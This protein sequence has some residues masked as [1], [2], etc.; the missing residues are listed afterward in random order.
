MRVQSGAEKLLGR[1][2]AESVVI[3][4][5]C[6][7]GNAAAWLAEHGHRGDYLGID[8]SPGLLDIACRASYPF[9]AEFR[10]ADFLSP[11]WDSPLA[12]GSCEFLLAFAVL[13]HLPGEAARK[14]FAAACRRLV[15][16]GGCVFLSSWQFLRSEKLRR[17]RVSWS[18]IGLRDSDVDEGDYLVDWR[19]EGQGLRYVHVIGDEERKSLA[20]QAGFFEM[21]FFRSDGEGGILA[22][23]AVWAPAVGR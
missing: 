9:F 5:G 21:E 1:I 3:D 15:R 14:E 20:S 2:P 11:G 7:N 17:R 22:D 18:D 8:A 12:D 4:L 13:H 16:P 19:R 23:Y 6:G 10:Q